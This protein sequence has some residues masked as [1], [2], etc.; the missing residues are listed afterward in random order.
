MGT[1]GLEIVRFRRRY[2]ITYHQ[3]D[4]G[5]EDLGAQIVASI[6]S[7][8][9]EYQSMPHPVCVLCC[10]LTS[11]AG[12]LQSMRAEY[13]AKEY[14]LEQGSHESQ[15]GGLSALPSELPRFN[16]HG[17]EY[18]YTIDL[19]REVLT[20]NHS[21]HWQL[22]NIPRQD[23]L[24]LHAM[25]DSIYR[26]KP[27]ISLDICSEDHMA[28]LALELPQRSPTI[29]YDFQIVTPKRDTTEIRTAFLTSILAEVFA[30]Y[31][32][33]IIR[34][35]REWGPDSFP[36]RELSFALVS[37]ASGHAKFHPLPAPPHGNLRNLGNMANRLPESPSE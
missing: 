28:S 11:F 7:D 3:Y 37:M 5:L 26:W 31:R 9:D 12:W 8:P 34:F 32:D 30:T 10:V 18:F 21:I 13:A 33:E 35:G 15:L 6:P 25:T 4:S 36:F 22:G 24:W 16:K 1:R 20:I 17:A 23:D 29:S 27:T 19:D 2:Y 14:E